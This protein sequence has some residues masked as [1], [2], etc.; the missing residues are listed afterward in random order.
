MGIIEKIREEIMTLNQWYINEVDN[1]NFW[2][3]HI[4]YVVKEAKI[5]ANK[6]NADQEIVELG[7][8]LH[9]IALMSNVGTKKDHH[10]NGAV[11]AKNLLSKY[12]YPEDKIERVVGCVLNH[13]SSKNCSNDEELC[14]ADAD[15]I[16][17][18]DNIVM[19]FEVAFKFNLVSD[20]NNKEEWIKYFKKDYDDLSERTKETFKDRYTTIMDVLFGDNLN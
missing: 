17:H 16:S 5:L 12:N 2:E 15:I 20:I 18:Y 14:V 8:L 13:K 6:Y 7:A 10:T 4:Q 19:C 9:D 11:I 1:Y 3:Q